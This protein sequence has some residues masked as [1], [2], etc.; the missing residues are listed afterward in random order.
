MHER[1]ERG[2]FPRKSDALLDEDVRKS[3]AP[4]A[5]HDECLEEKCH[6]FGSVHIDK[7]SAGEGHRCRAPLR[8][9]CFVSHLILL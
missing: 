1:H 4:G 5:K 3:K 8:S 6:F 9:R 7:A 2:G